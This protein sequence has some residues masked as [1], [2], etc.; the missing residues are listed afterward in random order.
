M[1]FTC[2]DL[3]N[4]S[5]YFSQLMLSKTL[6]INIYVQLEIFLECNILSI[7]VIFFLQYLSSVVYCTFAVAFSW[8]SSCIMQWGR[9]KKD[10]SFLSVLKL[11]W[12]R[13][14]FGVC[15]KSMFIINTQ[16]YLNGLYQK[17]IQNMKIIVFYVFQVKH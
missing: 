9:E 1:K 6:H 13:M 7:F 11:V 3:W 12:I 17:L 15:F 5:G 2:R 4:V 10:Y 16:I 8:T 14:I